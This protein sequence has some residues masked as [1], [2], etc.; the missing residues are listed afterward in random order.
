MSLL[1]DTIGWFSDK[2]QT[3]DKTT[4]QWSAEWQQQVTNLKAKAK[5]FT[6]VFKRLS[7][8]KSLAESDPKIA[9]EYEA[10][11]SKGEWIKNS[12]DYITN[13]IDWAYNT[14]FSGGQQ[15]GLV[16]GLVIP[17][18]AVTGAVAAITAWLADAYILDRKLDH[19][20]SQVAAGVDPAAAQKGITSTYEKG[21]L[22]NIQGSPFMSAGILFGVGAVIYFLWPEIRKR[23]N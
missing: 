8:K 7:A 11:M 5:E 1:D 20:E 12:V 4:E 14:F 23:L 21:S 15:L 2:L 9:G 18:V 6:E 3:I 19:I 16:Q 17:I 10:L 13:K 22:I